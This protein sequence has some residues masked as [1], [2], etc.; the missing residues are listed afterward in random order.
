MSD[1]E[2]VSSVVADLCITLNDA[3]LIVLCS[4]ILK[5]ADFSE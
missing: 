3:A 1:T 2:F 5:P 4:A